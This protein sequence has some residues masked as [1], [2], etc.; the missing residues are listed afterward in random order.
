M[1]TPIVRTLKANAGS[2]DLR[3]VFTDFCEA[4]AIAIRNRVDSH[5]FREREESYE[6]I[7]SR[8]SAS[9]KRSICA[10]LY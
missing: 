6:R 9:A 7:R 5:G 1:M 8:A 2:R 10:A 3:T 4:S